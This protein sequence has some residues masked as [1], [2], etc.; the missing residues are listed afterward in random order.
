MNQR[1]SLSFQLRRKITSKTMILSLIMVLQSIQR[2]LFLANNEVMDSHLEQLERF[3]SR[4]LACYILIDKS[5]NQFLWINDLVARIDDPNL[6]FI[7]LW[8][9]YNAVPSALSTVGYWPHITRRFLSGPKVGISVRMRLV[10]QYHCKLGNIRRESLL[11]RPLGKGRN[12]SDMDSHLL[13]CLDNC[14]SKRD[15]FPSCHRWMN[16]QWTNAVQ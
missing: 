9:H 2:Y 6:F 4:F 3:F 5:P 11:T 10:A 14:I 15:E 13:E 16:F 12:W 7:F 1:P 8:M